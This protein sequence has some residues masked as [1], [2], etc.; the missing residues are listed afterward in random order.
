MLLEAGVTVNQYS[1]LINLYRTAPCSVSTLAKTMKLDR[2]TLVRNI[3]PLAEMGLLR[4]L[5]E[6]GGRDRQ[7]TVAIPGLKCLE[8]A[9]R[10][11]E[12]AQAGLKNYIGRK[13]FE[14]FM[15][16]I[17]GLDRLEQG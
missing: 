17:A 3:K 15:S 13:D 16:V 10:L 1:L 6:E 12:K 2:T 4:D 14:T 9:Q 5:A 7:L 8:I 11:W